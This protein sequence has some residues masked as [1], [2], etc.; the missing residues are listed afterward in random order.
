MMS[1]SVPQGRTSCAAHS[2]ARS[3]AAPQTICQSGN[4][5]ALPSTSGLDTADPAPHR[6]DAPSHRHGRTRPE[7]LQALRDLTQPCEPDRCQL[8]RPPAAVAA[9]RRA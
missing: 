7:N 5:H 6:S 3:V 8:R 4:S 9:E 1:A 2:S